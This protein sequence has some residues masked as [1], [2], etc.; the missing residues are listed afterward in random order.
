MI[1]YSRSL[2]TQDH[3]HVSV[4]RFHQ[5]LR[6]LEFPPGNNVSDKPLTPLDA[7][8]SCDHFDINYMFVR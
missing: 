1:L 6:K 2:L 5:V 4:F 3:V 8:R 7:H